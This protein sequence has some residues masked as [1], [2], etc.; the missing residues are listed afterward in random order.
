MLHLMIRMICFTEVNHS[1]GHLTAAHSNNYLSLEPCNIERLTEF[2]E[3]KS[4]VHP[5]LYLYHRC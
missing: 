2:P 1:T 5:R 3:E 4:P